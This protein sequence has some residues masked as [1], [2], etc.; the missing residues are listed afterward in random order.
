MRSEA[1]GES[2]S[3]RAVLLAVALSILSAACGG[4]AAK[5]EDNGP[6]CVTELSFASAI[7]SISAGDVYLQETVNSCSTVDVSVLVA[8]LSGIWTVGFDL[9]YPASKVQYQSFTQGPL[10][11]KGSPTNQPL[12][13]VNNSSPGILQV[14]MTRFPPDAS[15]SAVGAE[16]LITFRFSKA[17]VG[18]GMIDFDSSQ[19]STV[20]E[21]IYDEQGNSRP[22]TFAPDHGGM[23]TV[24]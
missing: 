21:S 9:A 18:T 22:A 8:N 20:A 13:F 14:T 6:A 2:A 1:R 17:A 10:L 3:R 11:K 12:F 4:G 19:G 7:T 16:V 23:V 15:V 24:P 5:E